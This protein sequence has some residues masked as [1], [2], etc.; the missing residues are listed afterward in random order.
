MVR[1]LAHK[2]HVNQY[3]YSNQR[4]IKTLETSNHSPTL[5]ISQ[6]SSLTYLG[7]W[8]RKIY[9]SRSLQ[10]HRYPLRSE[11]TPVSYRWTL[12]PLDAGDFSCSC[13]QMR[14][15]CARESPSEPVRGTWFSGCWKERLRLSRRQSP[16]VQRPARK[17]S[18]LGGCMLNVGHVEDSRGRIRH[19]TLWISLWVSPSMGMP[20]DVVLEVVVFIPRGLI[21]VGSGVFEPT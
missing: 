8:P 20:V 14:S 3:K 9:A 4:Q 7:Y 19:E 11:S 10:A 18:E 13:P 15:W 17:V 1:F 12:A 5:T 16:T 6:Q 2:N 21:K